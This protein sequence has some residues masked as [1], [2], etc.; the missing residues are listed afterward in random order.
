MP[1]LDSPDAIKTLTVTDVTLLPV[2][3]LLTVIGELFGELLPVEIERATDA[4]FARASVLRLAIAEVAERV[5]RVCPVLSP[6]ACS[7]GAAFATPGE[8]DEHFWAV[9]VPLDD[10][11]LDGKA[12]AELS[13]D[14]EIRQ[15]RS[16]AKGS[17][18]C[19]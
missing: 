4:D 9:F 11:G 17:R 14:S 1:T 2:R 19:D 3:E 12:H 8:L 16:G 5:A 13:R 15:P 6:T 7:C 10:S 18:P